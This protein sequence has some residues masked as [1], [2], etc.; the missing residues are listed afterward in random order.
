MHNNTN[1]V[2]NNIS[3]VTFSNTKDINLQDI[4]K[5]SSIHL[6]HNVTIS[7]KTI[8]KPNIEHMIEYTNI[9][10]IIISNKY[11]F[12]Q[13]IDFVFAIK[14]ISIVVID[15]VLSDKEFDIIYKYVNKYNFSGTLYV[16]VDFNID[17]EKLSCLKHL[18]ITKYIESYDYEDMK[19]IHDTDTSKFNSVT[20][21]LNVDDN[22]TEFFDLIRYT[23]KVTSNCCIS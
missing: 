22:N 3:S 6:S 23:R 5:F 20:I 16:N 10:E 11:V 1:N 18:I 8:N 4:Y 12:H 2:S 17:I 19:L 9:K 14:S 21:N 7:D 15:I 13:L